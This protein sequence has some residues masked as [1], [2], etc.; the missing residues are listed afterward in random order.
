MFYEARLYSLIFISNKS[1][2]EFLFRTQNIHLTELKYKQKEDVT[3]IQFLFSKLTL[4]DLVSI[5]ELLL[6]TQHY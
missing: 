5:K 4:T 6:C 2:L 1:Q 3:G